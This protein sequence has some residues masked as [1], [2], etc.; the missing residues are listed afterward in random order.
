MKLLRDLVDLGP[1]YGYFPESEKIWHVCR[2]ED[3]AA[4]RQAFKE[5]GFPDMQLTEEHQYVGGYIGTL[6]KEV[7]WIRPKVETCVEEVRTLTRVAL[8]YPY[9]VYKGMCMSLQAEWQ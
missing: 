1:S 5:E 8:R 6:S 4:Y 7:A 3:E 9:A 2:K